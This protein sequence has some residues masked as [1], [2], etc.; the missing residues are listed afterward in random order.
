MTLIKQ[1]ANQFRDV[2]FGDNWT[3]VN[4]KET[5]ADIS[6]EEAIT[7]V[8][9]LNTI[10]LLVFHINF[11]LS[12]VLKVLRGE[13]LYASDKFS[14]DLPPITSSDD[15]QKLVTKAL[16]EAELFAAQIEKLEEAKLF[17]DFTDPQ[18]GNYYRNIHGI[19]E[20]TYYHLGQISLI[21]K[22][23]TETK[24]NSSF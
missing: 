1:I 21:K 4:F 2:Y 3:G 10:A 17:E 16:T 18:Y 23:L 9:N 5:V 20:H 13:P 24:S 7:K 19:I 6:W 14:F 8:Q 22:I 12:P 15:W 11:Y